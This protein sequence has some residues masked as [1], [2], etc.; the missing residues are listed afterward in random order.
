MSKS[1]AKLNR[2]AATANLTR[3]D[4]HIKIQIQFAFF[5][6]V[7]PISLETGTGEA[8]PRANVCKI[9]CPLL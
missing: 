9:K 1:M 8:S 7:P 2:G 5:G 4:R 6:W 3:T